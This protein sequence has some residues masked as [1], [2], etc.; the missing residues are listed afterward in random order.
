[1]GSGIVLSGARVKKFLR[2]SHLEGDAL[3]ARIDAP[4]NREAVGRDHL[5][6]GQEGTR[7]RIIDPMC[8]NANSYIIINGDV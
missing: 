7:I 3:V 6:K 1:M 5:L 4:A 8:I 2:R